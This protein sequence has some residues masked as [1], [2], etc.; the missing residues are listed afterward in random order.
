MKVKIAQP[1]IHRGRI[2]WPGETL[3]LPDNEG[4][5]AATRGVA[6]PVIRKA[7]PARDKPAGR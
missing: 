7:R 2:R 4:R 1:W 6:C 5:A 3:D